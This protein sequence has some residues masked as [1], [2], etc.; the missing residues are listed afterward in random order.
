MSYVK[1]AQVAAT[2]D[3]MRLLRKLGWQG[4]SGSKLN[5]GE[6]GDI[7]DR[8]LKE[9]PEKCSKKLLQFQSKLLSKLGWAGDVASLTYRDASKIIKG[10]YEKNKR[11]NMARAEEERIKKEEARLRRLVE[12]GLVRGAEI[13]LR[14]GDFRSAFIGNITD[15]S[16]DGRVCVLVSSIVGEE[17]HRKSGSFTTIKFIS[18]TGLL[19][20]SPKNILLQNDDNFK[21]KKEAMLKRLH[22]LEQ[23]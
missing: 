15:V 9:R 21:K 14:N 20:N 6:A 16:K 2:K 11:I 7:I 10:I 18:K 17:C 22:L 1:Y 8:L 4:D 3:Q 19:W 23:P 12:R 5:R 13:Y